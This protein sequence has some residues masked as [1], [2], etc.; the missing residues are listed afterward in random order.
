MPKMPKHFVQSTFLRN[1]R[2]LS[3]Q[4]LSCSVCDLTEVFSLPCL[5]TLQVG[6]LIHSKRDDG[7]TQLAFRPGSNDIST[8]VLTDTQ[9]SSQTLML[10]L[11]SC[12][13]LENFTYSEHSQ[14]HSSNERMDMNGRVDQDFDSLIRILSP[15]HNILRKLTLRKQDPFPR[16]SFRLCSLTQFTILERFSIGTFTMIDGERLILEVLPESLVELELD[17]FYSRLTE[18]HGGNIPSVIEIF[19]EAKLRRLPNLSRV[20]ILIDEDDCDRAGLELGKYSED[21]VELCIDRSFNL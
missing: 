19:T 13:A 7:L 12:T 20:V 18:S 11:Q 5:K 2:E 9:V 4:G 1:V 6:P 8:L 17:D 14:Y 3:L 15:F 10:V 16:E 21:G